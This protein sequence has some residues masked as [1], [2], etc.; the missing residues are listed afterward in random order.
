MTNSTAGL[1]LSQ[2]D[3]PPEL[4]ADF[5]RWYDEEHIPRRLAL[6]EFTSARRYRA[7]T[8][9]AQAHMVIYQ[10]SDLAVLDS[11]AYDDVK[12]G[13]GNTPLTQK[14]LGS[15]QNFTRYIGRLWS[16]SSPEL[17]QD[18]TFEYAF[19]VTFPVPADRFDDFDD[20][21]ENDHLPILLS[22]PGWERCRRYRIEE[23]EPAGP[24]AIAL[25]E[26]SDPAALEGPE[27]ERAR[28]TPWRQRLVEQEPWFSQGS[29]ALYRR[30]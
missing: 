4:E 15:T 22:A 8:P 30:R 19:V 24:T 5:D 18:A 21:Y 3:C 17:S 28:A 6:S 27:R 9:G 7:V 2:A 29:Y 26:L 12:R 13:S 1:L 20:W 25:H 11:P 14:M 23:G 16:D 10:M